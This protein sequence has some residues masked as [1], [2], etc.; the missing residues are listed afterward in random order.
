MEYT[1]VP[2]LKY[3]DAL[4]EKAN[5]WMRPRDVSQIL[6]I[7]VPTIYDWKYRREERKIPSDLF[8]KLNGQLFLRK[9][10][11]LAWINSQNNG[12]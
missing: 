8:V 2:I 11:L 6:G 10:V 5:S 12:E 7:P 9:Q 4:F 1:A 3:E